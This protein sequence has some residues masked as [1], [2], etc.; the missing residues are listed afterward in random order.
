MFTY[1]YTARLS[2]SNCAWSITFE[3]GVDGN[4][5]SCILILINLNIYTGRGWGGYLWSFYQN[6][7][8]SISL[9][10]GE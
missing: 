7:T 9:L 6:S 4:E 10:F 3:F 1:L 2:A 8:A 5:F